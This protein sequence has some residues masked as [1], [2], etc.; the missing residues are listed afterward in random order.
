VSGQAGGPFDGSAKVREF[1]GNVGA[2]GSLEG[3]DVVE[4][5]QGKRMQLI[6]S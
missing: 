2:D 3:D 1:G 5:A 6:Q 4:N